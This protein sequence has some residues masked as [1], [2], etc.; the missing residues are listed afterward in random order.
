M[1][2]LKKKKK[3]KKKTQKTKQTHK[4]REQICGCQGLGGVREMDQEFGVS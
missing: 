1:H 3:A 4:L 2:L